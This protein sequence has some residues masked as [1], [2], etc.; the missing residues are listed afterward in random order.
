MIRLE[1]QQTSVSAASAY[2]KAFFALIGIMLLIYIITEITPHAAKFVD[3]IFGGIMKD[4]EKNSGDNAEY[5]VFDIY[6]GDKN[7]KDSGDGSDDKPGSD[8]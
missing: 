4:H 8:C 7:F 5:K 6:D 3:K 1:E 2:I